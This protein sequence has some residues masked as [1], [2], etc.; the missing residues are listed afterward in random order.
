MTALIKYSFIFGGLFIM[1]GVLWGAPYVMIEVVPSRVWYGLPIAASWV[2]IF[3]LGGGLAA[4]GLTE[5]K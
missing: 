4:Y 2:L 1:Y 3:A 5:G